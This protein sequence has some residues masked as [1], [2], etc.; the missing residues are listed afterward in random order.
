MKLKVVA[1]MVTERVTRSFS[2]DTLTSRTGFASRWGTCA[3]VVRS[4]SVQ[5][6]LRLNPEHSICLSFRLSFI[7]VIKNVQVVDFELLH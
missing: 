6:I 2:F 7:V 4:L 5:D 3:F 1:G